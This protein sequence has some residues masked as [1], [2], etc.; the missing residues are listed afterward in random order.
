MYA[1]YKKNKQNKPNQ[2][3][4]DNEYFFSGKRFLREKEETL[5]ET[6]IREKVKERREKKEKRLTECKKVPL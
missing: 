1:S 4:V 5:W 2:K 6:C 3:Q